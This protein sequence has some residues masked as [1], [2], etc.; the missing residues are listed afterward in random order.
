MSLKHS[1]TLSAVC[2]Y[3]YVLP[4]FRGAVVYLTLSLVLDIYILPSCFYHKLRCREHFCAC[5][6]ASFL[7]IFLRIHSP[8]GT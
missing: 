6:S 8:K 4:S 7:I 5:I 1:D 3:I 2:V